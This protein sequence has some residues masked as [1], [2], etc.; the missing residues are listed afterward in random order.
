MYL[1]LRSLSTSRVFFFSS[2][3]MRVCPGGTEGSEREASLSSSSLCHSAWRCFKLEEEW[4][5][6][7]REQMKEGRG[8]KREGEGGKRERKRRNVYYN[9][10]LGIHEQ[11]NKG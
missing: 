1:H 9:Q 6:D 10:L 8:G 7:G 4:R 3:L 5:K 2:M 11:F